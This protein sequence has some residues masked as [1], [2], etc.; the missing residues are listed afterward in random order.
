M[1]RDEATGRA[2]SAAGRAAR[3]LAAWLGACVT[4]AIG[5]LVASL[6]V[7]GVSDDF[8][9]RGVT[10]ALAQY[11]GFVVVT[12]F[13]VAIFSSPVAVPAIIAREIFDWR[14][15]WIA[16][17]AGMLATLPAWWRGGTRA[18]A[19]LAGELLWLLPVGAVA[20]LAY[21]LIRIR[22]WPL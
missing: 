21:W 2:E 12:A 18:A 4:G 9:V 6:M 3:I 15:A 5:M 10:G 19:D 14:A 22:K 13:F 8:A 7:E 17:L 11:G 16:A 20:G 1:K